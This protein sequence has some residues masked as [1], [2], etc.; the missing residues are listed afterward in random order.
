MGSVRPAEAGTPYG[1]AGST[2]TSVRAISTGPENFQQP[3]VHIKPVPMPEQGLAFLFNT[4]GRFLIFAD[5]DDM[6][7]EDRLIEQSQRLFD[8]PVV[9]LYQQTAEELIEV[10]FEAISFF[11]SNFD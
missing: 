7:F 11:F 8:G 10:V 1:L 9:D 2:A 6:H 3:I 5:D 4:H